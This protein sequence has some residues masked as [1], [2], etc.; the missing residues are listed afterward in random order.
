MVVER[1]H[2][3]A[4]NPEGFD[5]AEVTFPLVD[6]QGCVLV[7]TNAYSVPLRAGSRVEARAYPLHMEVW[8]SGR[9]FW[10]PGRAARALS[11]AASACAGSGALS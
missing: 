1:D 5:L 7:K 11:S 3:T 10:P 9:P 2:L 8:H 6:K 4:R